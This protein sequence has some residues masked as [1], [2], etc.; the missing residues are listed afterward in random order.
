[1]NFHYDYAAVVIFVVVLCGIG[2]REM[3]KGRTNQFYIAM[4]TLSLVSTVCDFLPYAFKYPLSKPDIFLANAVNYGY[5]FCRNLC[6]LIYIL[7]LYSSARIWYKIKSPKR[8]I[9]FVL[10]YGAVVL[11]L[12]FNMI[13]PVFFYISPVTGYERREMIFVLYIISSL[14]CIISLVV[15]VRCR[16]YIPL[17]K[18]AA[19]LSLLILTGI[20]VLIQAVDETLHLEMFS[21]ALAMLIILLFVQR[22]E[23]QMDIH[24]R[25]FGWDAYRDEI[26]KI[27]M[28]GQEVMIGMISVVNADEVRSFV[29]EDR[30]DRFMSV[31]LQRID[32][33]IKRQ[34]PDNSLYFEYP[35]NIYIVYDGQ[36]DYYPGFLEKEYGRFV[37][38]AGYGKRDG[39]RMD[40]KFTLM[41]FPD[42][43]T[44]VEEVVNFGHNH[45]YFYSGE[46]SYSMAERFFV[47]SDFQVYN[48]I[49]E[50]IKNAINHRDFQIFYQPIYD[51]KQKKFLSAEALLR[52]KD[53][54]YGYVSPQ[55]VI[56]MAEK[57]GLINVIGDRVI[58]EVFRFV[59]S[60][61][62][63]ETGFEYVEINLSAHQCMESGFAEKL[64]AMQKE[65]GINPRRINFEITETASAE[66][67]KF[68]QHNLMELK[69][70][71][72]GFSL[73]DYGTGYSNI[74]RIIKLPLKIV[75]ID[76]TMVDNL[77][78]HKG[79]LIM[80]NTFHMLKDID[81]EIVVEGVETEDV[82]QVVTELG[83]DYI[84]GFFYARPMPEERLLEF[85]KES[86]EKVFD[87]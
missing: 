12:I 85:L 36:K 15:L 29:G 25:V 86:R 55:L 56:M 11:A 81:M 48:H 14:Y 60:D 45:T 80:K 77:K 71:G 82:A 41:K 5:F 43:L 4:V 67:N 1:M 42:V 21:M 50:I 72:F 10:P 58:E 40:T 75:K 35:G 63:R 83:C 26:S 84:Q 32:E 24:T 61:R 52:L 68:M 46:D 16:K 19:L 2:A 51:V 70:M 73:D 57:K 59:S 28:T 20:A 18:W 27:A 31:A 65:Y 53:P 34:S 78:D 17:G 69:E 8:F 62:F 38:L 54:E 6:I 13:K 64:K 33:D 66:F 37:Q 30:F 47:R 23:E 7:F 3:T 49:D 79:Y 39:A 76:K 9:P 87:K 22:P 44:T 74:Y